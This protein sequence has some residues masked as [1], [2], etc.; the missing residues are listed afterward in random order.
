M[1]AESEKI[2]ASL[3]E[4]LDDLE[5]N[6]GATVDDVAMLA[7]IQQG[8]GE[9]LA[10]NGSVESDIRRVLQERFDEGEL[11]KETYQ[12]VK[13]MLDRYVTED[14]ST[15]PLVT[16]GKAPVDDT[17]IDETSIDDADIPDGAVPTAAKVAP[18]RPAELG[19]PK[20]KEAD[21]FSS[22]AVIPNE[23]LRP[24][25]ADDQVQVGSVLR[26]RFLLQ[27]RVSGGSMGVVYK[28]LDRRLAETGTE[29]PYVAIKVLSPELAKSGS[30][31]RALQQEAAKGRRLNHP[32][33]VRFID[34]DRDDDLY[35][36]VMEWLEG[37]TLAQILDSPDGKRI[38]DG[39]AIE[40]VQQ[41]GEALEYAHKCGIVHADVKPG[42]VMILPNGE[43]RLFDF[44]VA[45]VLRAQSD[46]DVA[47]PA[48]MPAVT[49][50]YSSMQVLTGDNP[51]PADDVFSLA[52]L[53]YRLIAGY[54]V[55]GP[56]NAA[57]AAS[58]GMKP[59]PLKSLPEAQWRVLKKAISYS[60]VTR[61]G[62][63]ADFLGALANP[64]EELPAIV[65][66]E[67]VVEAKTSSK[68]WLVGLI[69]LLGILGFA[70]YKFDVLATVEDFIAAQQSI[71][72]E[73]ASG[74]PGE[75]SEPAD[76]SIAAPTSSDSEVEILV[77]GEP[78]ETTPAESGLVPEVGRSSAGA[79]LFEPAPAPLPPADHELTLANYGEPG[80]QLTVTL[81]ENA[82]SASIDL[83]RNSNIELPL[84]I[85]IEEVGHSGNRS[86]WAS[87]QMSV[88]D[89]GR[90]RFARGQERAR[91][92]LSMASDPLREA[93]QQATLLVRESDSANAE[94]ATI[95]LVLEDDDQRAFEAGL[96]ANTVAFASGQIAVGERDPAVQIDV[97][98]FN[99]DSQ[100]LEVSYSVAD[101][102]ASEGQDYFSA[103]RSMIRFAPG[104][105]TARL[106]IPLVQDSLSE[107]DE[108]FAVELQKDGQSTAPDVFHRVVVMIRD[109]DPPGR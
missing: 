107:G 78:I 75:A 36:I 68:S 67:R 24:A 77:G 35:F 26:D 47:E 5:E 83:K 9:L 38:T 79:S 55:F 91:V 96:P 108:A 60:R 69:V 56:R 84:D 62:S 12:L 94:L 25:T 22:T 66:E 11:R 42:N 33:I 28:A 32:G 92:V 57:E 2:R 31:L 100:A 21:A 3:A 90:F 85:R 43:T 51:V 20:E 72:P 4:Q 30:A 15:S 6:L 13:S 81:R 8:I 17:L 71:R 102:T 98:R 49:P 88:S 41:L 70:A 14:V 48:S 97:L 54:R 53:L 109:D 23:T 46:D 95:E 7:D 34:L 10:D 89:N 73:P 87:G 74:A 58:E 29:D 16:P 19:I 86:P 50:E 103:P 61:Y 45:R 40:I 76:A 18:D 64:V 39:R 93:D 82:G 80:P 104:Q 52:C 65:A 63:M 59:Q 27:E 106:L 44:G 105:R 99:P 1:S 101:V 37:R